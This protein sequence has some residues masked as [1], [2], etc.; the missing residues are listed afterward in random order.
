MSVVSVEVT[1][2]KYVITLDG[3]QAQALYEVLANL[4]ADGPTQELF[5]D[6]HLVMYPE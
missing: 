5:D 6:L 2:I 4:P 3:Q 1:K